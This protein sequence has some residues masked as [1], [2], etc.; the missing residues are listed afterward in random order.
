MFDNC[1]HFFVQSMFSKQY[2]DNIFTKV[3]EFQ[4]HAYP[5][6]PQAT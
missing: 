1:A 2:T 4:L 3:L 6:S 5:Q